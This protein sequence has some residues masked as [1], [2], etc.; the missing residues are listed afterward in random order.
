VGSLPTRNSGDT[1]N[2]FVKN[3]FTPPPAL[4]VHVVKEVS[5]TSGA[6]VTKF[7]H[8]RA[9]MALDLAMTH[10]FLKEHSGPSIW[11]RS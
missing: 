10:G 1:N 5:K 11:D 9:G 8:C 7:D 6:P 4:A 3:I 2:L